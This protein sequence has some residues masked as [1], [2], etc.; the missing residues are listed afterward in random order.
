MV[1]NYL[2]VS[3]DL[4]ANNVARLLRSQVMDEKRGS[5]L[6]SHTEAFL[7]EMFT[8]LHV[9]GDEALAIVSSL[10]YNGKGYGLSDLARGK[11]QKPLNQLS[12]EET[13]EVVSLLASPNYYSTNLDA[14]ANRKKKL[15]E[16]V[17]GIT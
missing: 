5:S 15:I 10:S 9:S 12:S 4:S 8:R 17:K 11:F 3:K 13:A 1:L 6:R 7:F 14:L 2:R 16:L